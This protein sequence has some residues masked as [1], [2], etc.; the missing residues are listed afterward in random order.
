MILLEER[1][2]WENG[3]S[4]WRERKGRSVCRKGERVKEL[5]MGRGR[6]VESSRG[7]GWEWRVVY[8]YGQ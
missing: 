6:E 3:E 4:E 1:K 5:L 8:W 2:R 7:T